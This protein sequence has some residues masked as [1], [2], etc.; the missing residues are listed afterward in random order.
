MDGMKDTLI[1]HA[2][3]TRR[4]FL[5]LGTAGIVGVSALPLQGAAQAD[6]VLQEA[7]AK[8]EY[9]TPPDHF[10]FAGRG[11]PPPY[12]LPPEKRREVGLERDTWNLEIVP[13]PESDCRVEHPLS[14]ELGTALDWA[15]LMKLAEKH[16][17]RYL[18]VMTCTNGADPFGMGLWEGVPLRELIWIVKPTVN[19][20]RVFY[21]GYH[22]DD[23]KQ[24]FQTSLPISRV[25]EV[26]PGE[27]PVI[28]C[29]KLNGEWLTP[30]GGAP[31]RMIVP[32]DYG[33]RSVKWIQRIVLTNNYQISDTYALWNNDT[34]SA[35]KTYA[36][37]L[38][39]PKQIKAGQP[40]AL[41]GVAQVGISGLSKVQW[42]L[43]PQDTPWSKDDPYFSQAP[44]KDAQ[45]LP[46]PERWGGGLPEGKLPPI[47][48]QI[49][50]RT[51]RPL[52]WPL[53]Y[54]LVHW[55]SLMTDVSPGR[56]LLRCRTIDNNGIAQPLPRPFPKSGNNPI[57]QVELVAE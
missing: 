6:P 16:A 47:P 29:Y 41:T 52:A 49:D 51:G 43:H 42:W 27:Q 34:E 55:A 19:V 22:N 39:V 3:L 36:R 11:S 4:Y 13:D 50:P 10:R 21:Y 2:E 26:P 24:L 23:P 40:A 32:S 5:G 15:G 48:G 35:L 33:N 8:L 46:P 12:Q 28:L 44:W 20:R 37:F 38:N 17:V 7:V 9:L 45:I 30:R 57:Q 53:P 1:Q 14:K 18:K 31:V 54:T 56:Y 25:L